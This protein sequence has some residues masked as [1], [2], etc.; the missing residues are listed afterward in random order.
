MPR[1]ILMIAFHF[2]PLRGSS[3][4]QRTLGFTR[5]LPE[6]GWTPLI[7]TAHPRAYP[8]TDTQYDWKLPA[9]LVVH[10]ACAFDTAKHFAIAGRYPQSL[11]L[12]DRWQSWH[13]GAVIEGL[14]MIRRH[15]PAAIW[16]TYP[17]ATAHRIGATLQKLSGLPWIADFRDPMAHTGYPADA[18]TWE[19]FRK[20][21]SKT[22][23]RASGLCFTTHGARRLYAQRYPQRSQ[24]LQLIANGFDEQAFASTAAGKRDWAAGR[25]LLLHSGIVYPEWRDPA[26]L[27][28]A[29]RNLRQQG[30]PD[31]HRLLLRFRACEHD[32]FVRA[33]AREYGVSDQIEILPPIPYRAALAE[34]QAADA[35]MILQ[36]D[37]CND[38]IP[39]KSYE[40]LRC[41]RPVLALTNE[42][43]DTAN[44]FKT[45]QNSILAALESAAEI[46]NALIRL[47]TS[48]SHQDSRE[49]GSQLD[50]PSWIHEYSRQGQ[51]KVL[52]H[53]LDQTVSHRTRTV[54]QTGCKTNS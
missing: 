25:W 46:S 33:R 12:P 31:V 50:L 6:F 1:K 34:M 41:G 43:S 16:S 18:R 26:S 54:T 32:E 3:G 47:L 42:G 15:Q 28:A 49:N 30:H 44:L 51:T 9:E 7:L 36:S 39:A 27:F 40:Y 13:W 48:L 29:L 53:L 22:F 38:Q 17:I 8:D 35:L 37:T 24:D 20:V 14:R 4:I 45:S 2:P 11:A 19:S 5:H 23:E 21:E 10:R 52:A